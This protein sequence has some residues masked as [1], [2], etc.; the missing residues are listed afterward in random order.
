M[1]ILMSTSYNQVFKESVNKKSWLCESIEI[2]H[3]L[4]VVA[5][6]NTCFV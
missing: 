5:Y 6:F 1:I 4:V 2:I 3:F